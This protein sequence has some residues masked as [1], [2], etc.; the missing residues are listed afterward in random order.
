MTFHEWLNTGIRNGWCGPAICYTHDGLPTTEQEDQEFEQG[1]PCIHILRLY[2]SRETKKEIE[3]N[4][5]PSMW[6]KAEPLL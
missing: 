1:D 3:N 2:D 6:R 5:T 4:H